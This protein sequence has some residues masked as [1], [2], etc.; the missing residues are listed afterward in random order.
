L[1][2]S[3]KR[4]RVFFVKNRSFET[5]KEIELILSPEFYWVKKSDMPISIFKAK[6]L[7]PAVFEG[8]LPDGN[9]EFIAYK[10]EKEI[11]F[12]AYN[13]KEI[14]EEIVKSGL[15]KRKIAG[16]YFAQKELEEIEDCIEVD[17]FFS[18]GK[19][20]DIWALLPTACAGKGLKI[21]DVLQKIKLS[22]LRIKLFKSEFEI[23]SNMVLFA[24]TLFVLFVGGEFLENTGLKRK[25]DVFEYKKENIL[26]KH[27]LPKTSFE[28]DSIERRLKKIEKRNNKVKYFFT[29]VS[30][31]P[32]RAGDRIES[33]NISGNQAAISIICQKDQKTVLEKYFSKK[34]PLINSVFRENILM[35]KCEI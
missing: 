31:I 9:F 18:L 13:P 21:D 6:K 20:N 16:I 12:I 26:M 35:L 30:K 29:F 7:A 1:F 3:K 8:Q 10:K 28:L 19:V 32:L 14:E 27:S 5:N 25:I 24:F 22:S 23:D 33:I 34:Y 15:D 17:E 2:P 4:D 11:F